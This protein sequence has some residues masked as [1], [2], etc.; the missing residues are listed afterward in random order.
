MNNPSIPYLATIPNPTTTNAPVGPP[1]CVE[2]PPKAEIAKPATIA[3][4]RPDCGGTPDAIAKAIA[5][6]RATRPTVTPARR[7]DANRRGV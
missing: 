7:S 2:E 4:Y 1:I 3:Q 6:G 5:K